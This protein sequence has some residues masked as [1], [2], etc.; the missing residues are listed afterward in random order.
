MNMEQI[1]T[2]LE[3]LFKE[4]LKV[5]EQR[6]LIFWTDYEKQFVDDY[7]RIDIEDVKVV[8][9]HKNNQFYIKH[10][11]EEEDPSS[12]YLIYTNM[13]LDS[14]QNW[15]YDTVKYSQTF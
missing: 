12:S 7:N 14:K 15:L 6:K 3:K 8:H 4:L 1:N 5:G 10:L 13:E 2:A 9:L 11:L